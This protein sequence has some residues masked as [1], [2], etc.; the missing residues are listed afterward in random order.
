M[1]SKA[2]GIR[3]YYRFAGN[4]VH[5]RVFGGPVGFTYGKAG[6]L[7]FSLDEFIAFERHFQGCGHFQDLVEFIEDQP[8]APRKD[9]DM[10]M[11]LSAMG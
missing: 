8:A 10:K 5:L 7:C 1:T 11:P 2:Y 9:E 6:D 4:H 3:I